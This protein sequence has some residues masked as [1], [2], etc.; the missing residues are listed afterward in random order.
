MALFD[1]YDPYPKELNSLGAGGSLAQPSREAEWRR[2]RELEMMRMIQQSYLAQALGMASPVEAQEQMKALSESIASLR[3]AE[4]VRLNKPMPDYMATLTGWRGW[5][6]QNERLK[7][8]GKE[9]IWEPCKAEAAVCTKEAGKHPAPSRECTCGYWSFKSME[10]LEKALTSYPSSVVVIGSVEIWG[11]VIEC[12]NGY[13]S[14]FAYPKE[15]WLLK[16]GMEYLSWTYKVP[17]RTL[18]HP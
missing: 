16:P 3:T 1:W 9:G 7:A 6:I 13:R 10:T 17:V 15:L 2:Q 12:E 5:R 8:L 4:P 18:P 14:E 11:R